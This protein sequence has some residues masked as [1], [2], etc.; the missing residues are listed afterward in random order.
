M[1]ETIPVGQLGNELQSGPSVVDREVLFTLNLCEV[2]A[3]P[4]RLRVK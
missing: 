4:I 2:P 1:G 3:T